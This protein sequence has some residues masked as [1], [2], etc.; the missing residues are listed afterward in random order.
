ML[1]RSHLSADIESDRDFNA[2]MSYLFNTH[3]TNIELK[4]TDRSKTKNQIKTRLVSDWSKGK[5]PF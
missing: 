2:L 4:M 5:V 1:F 3:E